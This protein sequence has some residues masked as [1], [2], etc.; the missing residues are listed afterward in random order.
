MIVLNSVKKRVSKYFE[1]FVEDLKLENGTNYKIIGKNGSG[2]T[3]LLKILLGVINIDSGYLKI[4]GN[5][6]SGFFGIERMLDFVTPKEYFFIVCKSYGI[7][8]QEV[9]RRFNYIN[10]FFNRKYF[11]EKKKICDYSDGNKQLIG[12]I[13]SCLPF[14]DF[15]F[16]DEPF[17]Y[18]DQ[19]TSFS[20]KKMLESLNRENNT[21]VFYSDNSNSKDLDNLKLYKI[22]D[23]VVRI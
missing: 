13:A 14:T 5:S 1:L 22:E 11:D 17:N 8:K 9:I 12:I 23:G 18:L 7:P 19:D 10:S 15:V 21:S 3:I 2:K 6:I 4:N 16:L 20:L